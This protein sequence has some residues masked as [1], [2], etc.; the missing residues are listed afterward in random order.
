LP[1][2]AENS[3]SDNLL[4]ISEKYYNQLVRGDLVLRHKVFKE[5]NEDFHQADMINEALVRTNIL[6]EIVKS[7]QDLDDK[8][9][10]LASRCFSSVANTHYGRE[11][12]VNKRLLPNV[13][14]LF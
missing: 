14:A 2:Q 4:T 8:T 5:M 6:N 3:V 10:E 13:S 11:T 12:L 7:C 9:R 1:T